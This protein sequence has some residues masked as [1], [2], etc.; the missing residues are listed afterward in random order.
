[1]ALWETVAAAITTMSDED[2]SA[3][4][5]TLTSWTRR[6]GVGAETLNEQGH[7]GSVYDRE[8]S[9]SR[10]GSFPGRSHDLPPTSGDDE[11]KCR[12][13]SNGRGGGG[14]GYESG[15]SDYYQCSY[16]NSGDG[17]GMYSSHAPKLG[18]TRW[19]CLASWVHPGDSRDTE[20]M[21]HE[22][23]H[24]ASPS[25]RGLEPGEATDRGMGSDGCH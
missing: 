16:H 9:S 24:G 13:G 7:G 10:Q 20:R 8:N 17:R 22:H 4:G 5:V 19:A 23:S 14:G 2:R 1:M 25:G 18:W 15:Q 11:R 12:G 6:V 3:A 21:G